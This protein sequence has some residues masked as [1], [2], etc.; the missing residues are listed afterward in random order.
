ML[1]HHER[2][3]PDHTQKDL[4]RSLR[5][6]AL[7]LNN[8]ALRHQSAVLERSAMRPRF[9]KGDRLLS[10]TLSTVWPRWPEALEILQADTVKCWRQLGFW[11][12]L[13]RQSRR[14]RPG[15]PAITPEIRSLIQRMSLRNVS[16]GAPH[17]HDELQKLGLNVC[18]TTVAKYMARGPEPPSQRGKLPKRFIGHVI[19]LIANIQTGE[20]Y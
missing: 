4:N 17:I 13:L 9:A 6:M 3:S 11:H 12:Y 15:R 8:M 16:W 2:V 18:Q 10:V 20:P 1:N 5:A 14:R 7:R 19:G